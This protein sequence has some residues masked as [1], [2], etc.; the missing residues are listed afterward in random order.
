VRLFTTATRSPQSAKFAP[1]L[2]A[3][4]GAFGGIVYWLGVQI[5]PSSVAAILAVTVTA[6]LNAEIRSVS[7]VYILIKYSALMALS[8][9]TLPFAAP[10]NLPLGLIMICG[11]AASFA[12]VVSAMATRPDQSTAKV[13][14]AALGLALLCGFAPAALLGIPGLIGVAVAIVAHLGL[15]TYRRL[16]QVGSATDSLYMTQ[17]LT[18]LCFYLGALAT[19]RYV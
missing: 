19:W 6:A 1:L 15:V 9:A 10:A 8:T 5:W 3:L 4:L 13:S 7:V 11:Y 17:L 12:L 18:E 2:G 14:G 16:H